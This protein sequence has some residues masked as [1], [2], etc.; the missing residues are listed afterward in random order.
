MGQRSGNAALLRATVP[1][2]L[3]Y[4]SRLDFEVQVELADDS[5]ATTVRTR[6][7]GAP[8]PLRLH[9]HV[10]RTRPSH[11]RHESDTS[12]GKHPRQR[13]SVT[14]LSGLPSW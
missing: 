7:V 3:A 8:S 4:P 10:R 9:V 1:V 6:N 13:C 5:I 2:Q 12:G 14:I 11:R